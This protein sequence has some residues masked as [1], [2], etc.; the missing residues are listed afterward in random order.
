MP[1]DMPGNGRPIVG[2]PFHKIPLGGAARFPRSQ[3][4][5][6]KKLTQYLKIHPTQRFKVAPIT[7]AMCRVWRI[8]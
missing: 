6:K 8:R 3:H 5:V 4:T 7:P 2:Y 1:P